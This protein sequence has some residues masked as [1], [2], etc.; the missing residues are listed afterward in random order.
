MQS[1]HAFAE[2][3]VSTYFFLAI[4]VA[5]GMAFLIGILYRHGQIVEDDEIES[6]LSKNGSY[7]ITNLVMCVSAV[8]VAY[9]TVSS[10]LPTW[11]P[12]GGSV[13]AA[14]AFNAVARPVGTLFC[15]LMAV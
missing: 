14:G 15:L 8:L 12:L 6:L 4:M 5:A 11:M 1:V 9:L 13:I 10:A 7:Y 2:D 3:P